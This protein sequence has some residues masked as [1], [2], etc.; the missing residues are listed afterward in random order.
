MLGKGDPILL[1]NGASDIMDA[2]D[3]SFLTSLSSNH[4]VI[5]FDNRGLGNTTMGSKPYTSQQLANDASGM[6]DALKIPKA[7][8]MGYSLG[9]FI[10]QQF[11]IMYPDKVHS[12]VLVAS[13]CGGK[14]HTPS[15]P[16][17]LKLEDEIVNKSLNNV[18]I[19]QEEMKK[20]VVCF[21]RIWM[22]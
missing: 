10:T 19:S 8:I 14:D 7:D 16:E 17:F 11:T 12:F 6:L 1:F 22:A 13:S 15:P 2:W 9:S 5:V 3:L 18:S 4:T 20:L 21:S